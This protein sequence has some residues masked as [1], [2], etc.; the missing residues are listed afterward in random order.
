[1]AGLLG[2]TTAGACPLTDHVQAVTPRRTARL[3]R[4]LALLPDVRGKSRLL[5]AMRPVARRSIDGPVRFPEGFVMEI[6]GRSQFEQALYL[7]AAEPETHS[8]LHTLLRR[9][10]T[11]Y[12]GGANIGYFTLLASHLVG[13]AG[14]VVAFE[15]DSAVGARL[16]RHLRINATR[17]VDVVHA[18]LGASSGTAMVYEVVED[19]HAMRTVASPRADAHA[20]GSCPMVT[21]DDEVSRLG[22]PD[23]TLVKLDV[24]GSEFD[25]ILGASQMISRCR[26]ALIVE[27]NRI[28]LERFGKTPA[29]VI[30]AIQVLAPYQVFWPRRRRMV[31][32]DDPDTLPHERIN[33]GYGDNYFFR[34][35]AGSS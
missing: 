13:E 23:P 17:N 35:T 1:M 11:F 3:Y 2:S 25:T 33:P 16:E 8:L 31:P 29:D 28:T 10:D 20:I 15:A 21:L 5:H 6:D 27:L 22:L 34:V 12:D 4:R 30:A 18:A 14:R 26:P 19:E 24:E 7:R 32:V 9:G